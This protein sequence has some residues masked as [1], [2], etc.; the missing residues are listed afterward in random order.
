MNPE[1]NGEIS[2]EFFKK[3]NQ[4]IVQK[5][6]LIKLLQLQ[7]RN[8]KT[9]IEAGGTG[10]EELG[11]LK[12]A[13]EEK[14]TESERLLAE[15]EAQKNQFSELEQAKDEQIKALSEM[16]EQ[17]QASG[18]TVAEVVEDP[19]VAE[20]EQVV[21]SL[22]EELEKANQAVGDLQS[23]LTSSVADPQQASDLQMAFDASQAEVAQLNAAVEEI[24]AQLMAREAELATATAAAG[25]AS[26]QAAAV[27]EFK[28][29]I[30]F[31]DNRILELEQDVVSLKSIIAEKDEAAGAGAGSSEELVKA[32]A[33]V[34]ELKAQIASLKASPALPPAVSDELE[35]L[36]QEVSS[37]DELKAELDKLRAESDDFAEAA[38]KVTALEAEREQ[39]ANE[40]EGL[41]AASTDSD[42]VDAMKLEIVKLQETLQNREDELARLRVSLEARQDESM[43]D[44]AVREEVEQ[45]TRQVAD[46]L[47]AIQNFESMI[48]RTREQL[49]QKD[50]E[51]ELLKAR[52]GGAAASANVI[53]VTGENEIITSFIDFFD[54]LDSLL[55]KNPLPELQTLHQKLLDRLIIPNQITYM[56]VIS[57]EYDPEKHSATDYFRSS[58]F[59]ER[60]IVFEVEKGYR[61]GDSVIKKS[62]VWVVQNLFSC[63]AC[64]ATQSNPDSR[65]CHLC[66]AKIVAP[67]GLPVDSL[68]EFE[69]S[70]ITYQRFA[71]RMLELNDQER[72][73]EYILAG[74]ELDSNFV[75]LMVRLADIYMAESKFEDAMDLL[76]KAY[77]LKPDPKTNEKIQSLETKLSIFKQAK[78]LKLSPEEFEKLLHLIQK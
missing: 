8:L 71:E 74:L 61:K 15:L 75:P 10:S 21:S 46:Q 64:G 68:P 77:S 55:I 44:P 54:G 23:Q 48:S 37:M 16:L 25:D 39:L 26:A 36:R 7:I 53:P 57:E 19:R 43:N 22:R 76:K 4:Q 33:E 17:H 70:P 12:K 3:L 34:E 18:S 6:N 9:Q 69:P 28:T 60:C 5:D 35:K 30:A 52:S 59:P 31:R 78:N 47:L 63:L 73:R 49:K 66:G 62:K 24:K 56:Q 41:K 58:K 67:N 65:F 2:N 50:A 14:S 45:L 42:Q 72:A 32:M 1:A 20:L 29:E 27:E 51:I 38:M 40:I 11:Q 13:L